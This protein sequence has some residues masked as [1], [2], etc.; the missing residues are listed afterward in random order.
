MYLAIVF[1]RGISTVT[2]VVFRGTHFIRADC[3]S[4]GGA[5]KGHGRGI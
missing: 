2:N 4:A 5:Y 3:G 1:L